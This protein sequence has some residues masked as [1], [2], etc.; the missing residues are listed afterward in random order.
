MKRIL[1]FLIGMLAAVNMQA[2][3]VNDY[4][5][6][7]MTFSYDTETHSATLTDG[8]SI[9]SSKV[10]IPGSFSEG[11]TLYTVTSIGAGAFKGNT[12]NINTTNTKN[13]FYTTI[14]SFIS[15][16]PILHIQYFE[17]NV[18]TIYFYFYF[19]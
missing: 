5:Y 9:A 2:E 15:F 11:G 4:M 7:G 12:N 6:Q 13:S 10:V 18:N 17:K 1:L 14:S 16:N 19:F 8:K 3:V